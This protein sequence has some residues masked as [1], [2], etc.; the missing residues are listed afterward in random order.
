MCSKISPTFPSWVYIVCISEP[1]KNVMKLLNF[2]D[3]AVVN[4]KWYNQF[5]K[6]SLTLSHKLENKRF[7]IKPSNLTPMHLPS[8]IKI[9]FH[10]NIYT[11]MFMTA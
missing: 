7:T 9:Y 4:V 8:K 2:S 10:K 5:G 3:I 6:N 11:K 1:L